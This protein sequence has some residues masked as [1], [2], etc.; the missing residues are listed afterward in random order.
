MMSVAINNI[1]GKVWLHTI[2]AGFFEI[3]KGLSKKFMRKVVESR[4][5]ER[6]VFL[7]SWY[8]R[9]TKIRCDSDYHYI[10]TEDEI[11]D[12]LILVDGLH[13]IFER[14]N[15]FLQKIHSSCYINT[16]FLTLECLPDLITK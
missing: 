8:T 16:T 3:Q 9:I 13:M 10:F 7:N 4:P 12:A 1:V 14:I 2:G 11:S 5:S 6:D 15:P